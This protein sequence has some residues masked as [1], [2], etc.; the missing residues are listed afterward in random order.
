MKISKKAMNKWNKISSEVQLK[1][2]SNV[3]CSNCMKSV[4][5]NIIDMR[6]DKEDNL[7]INGK[8]SI[9]DTDVSRLIE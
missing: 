9:C 7:I 4:R 3:F 8:C 2:L 5:V 1:I 6:L